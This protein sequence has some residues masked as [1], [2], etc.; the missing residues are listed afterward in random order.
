M[1]SLENQFEVER[2]LEYHGMK[3]VRRFDA[4]SYMTIGKAMDLHDVSRGRTS[5]AAAMKRVCVPTL[6]LGIWSDFLYPEYQQLQIRDMVSSNGVRT[7]HIEIDSPHGHDA[8][9]IDLDQVG[10]PIK[11]F[12][13]SVD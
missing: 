9:L 2:Y 1:K 12:L 11:N 4:N 5:L 7:T 10:P 3:L 13:E 6:T 8:F